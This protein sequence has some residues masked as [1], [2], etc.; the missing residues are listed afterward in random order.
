MEDRLGRT[1]FRTI[2]ALA[3]AVLIASACTS[4]ASPSTGGVAASPVASTG[5]GAS[6]G[7]PSGSAASG[8]KHVAIVNK[9]MTDDEI[10][11]AIASEGTV[12]VGNWTYSATSEIVNQFQKYVKDT[13]GAD[14][15]LNYV[16]SQ[17]PSEYLTKLAADQ[18]AG[19]K[20][21]FDVIAVEENYW[22]DASQQGLVD[23]S[24]K[25]DLI[26]NQSMVLDIFKHEQ[27]S[28]AFQSTAYPGVVY[29]KNDAGYLKKLMDLADPRLKGKV[30]L[31]KPTD[32]TAGGLLL[33][34]ASE[35]GKDYKD[36]EQ[37]KQV[38]DW[39]VQNLGPNVVKY[40]T[41]QATPQGLFEQ[42]AVDAVAF[43]NSL[44]RLEYLGGHQEAALLV[45][46]TIYPANGYLW[47]PK[48]AQHPVL[49]QVFMNWRLAKDVQFPNA[50]P[51]DHGQWSELSEGFLGPDYVD[52]V[53]DW[54]K[55]D[56]F[57]Y[58][59]TL[60]QIQ[61]GFK[62]IDWPAY[63]ASSKVFLDYY[64]QQLGQ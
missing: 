60:D 12:T 13:F 20:A 33:G 52:Q 55:S 29:D 59:P 10:K 22:Y 63:N 42:G 41:D 45:P 9:D 28:I 53:P 49:A 25:S 43:W 11:A 51:I 34:L 8:T 5:G 21:S 39:A 56:Y 31:P 38:V 35:M 30:T 27:Q 1:R 2:G 32:I 44:A 24:L 3:A 16:G 26:P 17:Q 48:N 40:T 36:P 23:D 57:T 46:P 47:V 62:A 61:T 58:F 50:W 7:G 15:K 37:M 64:A 19:N 14:I 18:K 54:F 4:G 6:S